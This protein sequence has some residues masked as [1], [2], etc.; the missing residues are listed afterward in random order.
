MTGE[1]TELPIGKPHRSI[2]LEAAERA[3]T[4]A[5]RRAGVARKVRPFWDA[6]TYI[7]E[8]LLPSDDLPV[9][10]DDALYYMDAFMIYHVLALHDKHVP[11]E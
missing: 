3:F 7:D 10:V 6:S 11:E 1:I 5:A 4:A 9:K 8:C 2:L